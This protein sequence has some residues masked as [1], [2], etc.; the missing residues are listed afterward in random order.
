MPV[1]WIGVPLVGAFG[2]GH[3][4]VGDAK[5]GSKPCRETGP[6]QVGADLHDCA[7]FA[8]EMLLLVHP[9]NLGLPARD[10][11]HRRT[12]ERDTESRVDGGAVVLDLV[13]ERALRDT[14]RRHIHIG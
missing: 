3:D 5:A 14:V 1:S 7:V 4:A 6:A 13:V 11:E 8:L 10:I 2:W 9:Q 12:R